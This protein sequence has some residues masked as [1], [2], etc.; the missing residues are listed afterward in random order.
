MENEIKITESAEIKKNLDLFKRKIA[1]Q[2]HDTSTSNFITFIIISDLVLD[3]L[4][5][6]L[7]KINLNRTQFGILVSLVENGGTAI[8]SLLSDKVRRSKY[9]ITM[10][11][12]SLEKAGLTKSKKTEL[13]SEIKS[14]RRLRKVSITEKGLDAL[15]N[16]LSL[17]RQIANTMMQSFNKEEE[18]QFKTSLDSL[19]DNLHKVLNKS[20][21]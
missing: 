12:D 15:K 11:V 2:K 14:D 16:A 9:A 4:E 21:G 13:D 10:A 5:S 20:T 6:E 7:Q 3:N 18:L 1:S 17:N 8:P 19:L